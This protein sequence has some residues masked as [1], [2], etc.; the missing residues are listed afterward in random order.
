MV[1]HWSLSDS[2]SP[3]VSRTRLSILAI[4]S[5]A[6]VWIV[7]TRPPTS[8]FSRPFNNPLVTVLNAL[9]TIGTLLS[10][11]FTPVLD[12]MVF[13]CSLSDNKYSQ[14]SMTLP[15]NLTDLNNVPVWM[16]SIGPPLSNPSFQ[17]FW[18][19][20]HV[21]KANCNW[22]YCHYHVQQLS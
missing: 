7:S 6:V 21:R 3:Q 12:L 16:V 17:S 1:F 10:S 5:N 11:F 20:F 9:I 22:Y 8:K 14:V 13:H 18:G 2:K 19:P 4:L 15:S